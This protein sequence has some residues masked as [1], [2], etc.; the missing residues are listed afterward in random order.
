MGPGND[1]DG[2][3]FERRPNRDGRPGS[4]SGHSTLLVGGVQ[5]SLSLENNLKLPGDIR[6]GGKA[7][8]ESE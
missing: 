2:S 4:S 5:P 6:K 1:Y 3:A 8:M 7:S